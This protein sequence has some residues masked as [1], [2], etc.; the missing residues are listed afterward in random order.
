MGFI[1][2]IKNSLDKVGDTL[3]QGADE[4]KIRSRQINTRISSLER[5]RQQGKKQ[6]IVSTEVRHRCKNCGALFSGKYCFNCGQSVKT[7]RLTWSSAIENILAGFTNIASG[8]GF[9]ILEL[10]SRPGYMIHDFIK[11]KRIIY[12]KPFQMLFVLAAVY[13][14]ADQLIYPRLPEAAKTEIQTTAHSATETEAQSRVQPS[15]HSPEQLDAL[16][17]TEAALLLALAGTDSTQKAPTATPEEITLAQNKQKKI[18]R[19]LK[20][21]RNQI[22]DPEADMSFVEEM[23]DAISKE[24]GFWHRFEENFPKDHP[25]LYAAGN[26]IYSGVTT[27]RALSAIFTLPFLAAALRLA[28]RKSKKNPHYNFIE[29]L[30]AVCYMSCQNLIV[31]IL[32]LPFFKDSSSI[33]VY[34]RII[35]AMW[36]LKELYGNSFLKTAWRYTLTYLLLFLF[37]I[38]GALLLA[39]VIYLIALLFNVN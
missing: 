4:I 8:F 31:A 30:F 26:A 15:G 33:H 20:K 28:F 39:L 19:E 23:A 21:I 18:E 9:T 37:V 3:H 16:K 2:G 36:L 14:L 27:N 1:T 12:T 25:Y 38:V 11:G 35:L 34:I 32:L 5:R 13:A 6:K 17:K 10:F 24:D 22:A 29:T 7:E